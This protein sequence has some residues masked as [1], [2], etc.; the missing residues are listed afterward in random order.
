MLPRIAKA[1]ALA[2]LLL[3]PA[4]T[5]WIARECAT[6]APGPGGGVFFEVQKGASVRAVAGRLAKEKIIRSSPALILYYNL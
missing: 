2:V 3:L 6:P 4:L 5:G 1:A